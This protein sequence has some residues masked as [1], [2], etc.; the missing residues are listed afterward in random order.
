MIIKKSLLG[1]DAKINS[2]FQNSLPLD[3]TM[4]DV[5]KK[6]IKTGKMPTSEE[7]LQLQRLRYSPS[8]K[9]ILKILRPR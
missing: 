6:A 1:I 2:Q 4:P 8:F 5:Q 9:V 3:L 7:R